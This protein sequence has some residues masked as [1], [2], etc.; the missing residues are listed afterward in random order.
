M[1]PLE[2]I[3]EEYEELRESYRNFRNTQEVT[4]KPLLEYQSRFI[5]LK[6][7]LRPWVS[8]MVAEYTKR[9]DKAATS[10]KYRLT[11]AMVK[12]TYI[13]ANG[14]PIYDTPPS[15]THAEKYAAASPEY[16]KFLDQRVFYKE[17]YTNVQS[18]REDITEYINSTK[19]YL[20]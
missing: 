19:Q 6:A 14:V 16:K 15:I 13:P 9:D 5:D 7:D 17:G 8:K 4:E 20:K 18:L 12:D 2:D 11:L 3:I 10:I 1:R